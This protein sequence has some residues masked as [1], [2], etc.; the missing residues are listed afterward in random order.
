MDANKIHHPWRFG[1]DWPGERC[2]AKTRQ[3]TPCQKPALRGKTRCQLHG[4]RAGAPEG[5]RNG[6]YNH[7]RFTKDTKAREKAASDRIEELI[8][9]GRS[10]G[11]FGDGRI[12][13]DRLP[14]YPSV[15]RKKLDI[16]PD[17]E[18]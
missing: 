17:P 4:G 15:R 14:F 10:M 9:L 13:G 8:A 2:G 6:N 1:P 7:G 11:M 16:P 3:G 5:K 12:V 18:R